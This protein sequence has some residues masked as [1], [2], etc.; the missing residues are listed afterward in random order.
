[1]GRRG[2]HGLSR[3]TPVLQQCSSELAGLQ[4][5]DVRVQQM[6]QAGPYLT[7]VPSMLEPAPPAAAAQGPQATYMPMQMQQLQ[8]YQMQQFQMQQMQMMQMQ[9]A[10]MQQA[11]MVRAQMMSGQLV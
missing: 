9:Q 5:L 7:S 11:Q 10:R 4:D 3:E 6:P 2:Q 8:Q 1:M